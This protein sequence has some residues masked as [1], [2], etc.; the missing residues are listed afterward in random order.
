MK[1]L[2]IILSLMAT[3]ASAAPFDYLFAFPSQAAAIA[4]PVVGQ[5]YITPSVGSPAWRGDICFPNIFAWDSTKDVVNGDG[6][7]THTSY[8]SNWLMICNFPTRQP[9]LEAESTTHLIVDIALS[10]PA[11]MIYS[12]VPPAS[13]STVMLQPIPQGRLY[14]FG[15]P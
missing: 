2:A 14:P 4:D 8:D 1:I 6:S 5:Y 3:P 11:S 15:N 12:W 13:L 7:I 9:A 10:G